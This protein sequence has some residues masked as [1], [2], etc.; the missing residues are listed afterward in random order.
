MTISLSL[1]FSEA[2]VLFEPTNEKVLL[3]PIGTFDSPS[4]SLVLPPAVV[5]K[6]I[7]SAI[8]SLSGRLGVFF[9]S[10]ALHSVNLTK[11]GI[12]QTLKKFGE[13]IE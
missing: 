8:F 2:S 12:I 3:T 10:P 1:K 5:F 6:R 11:S 4:F 13:T 7:V 9:V